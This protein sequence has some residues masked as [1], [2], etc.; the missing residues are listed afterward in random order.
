MNIDKEDNIE[1]NNSE[2]RSTKSMFEAQYKLKL[3]LLDGKLK[4]SN[5]FKQYR[6]NISR[7]ILFSRREKK[8]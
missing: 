7:R 8:N 4:I 3:C 5:K 2:K 1:E 6:R